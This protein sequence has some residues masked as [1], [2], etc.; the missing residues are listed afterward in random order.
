MPA[1]VVQEFYKPFLPHLRIISIQD[2]QTSP[3]ISGGAKLDLSDFVVLKG[4][5]W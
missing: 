4:V 5:I 2:Y 1:P 3:I